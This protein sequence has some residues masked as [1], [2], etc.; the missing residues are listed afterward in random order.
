M[1]TTPVPD[2]RYKGFWSGLPENAWSSK[3]EY[4]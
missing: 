1:L 3:M 4:L 2:S